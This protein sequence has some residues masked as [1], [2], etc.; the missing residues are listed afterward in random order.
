MSKY[1]KILPAPAPKDTTTDEISS[2]ALV[3]TQNLIPPIK[4]TNTEDV[5][6][7]KIPEKSEGEN[8][9][10]KPLLE[11]DPLKNVAQKEGQIKVCIKKEIV[12]DQDESEKLEKDTEMLS[13]HSSV[14]PGT[15][16]L[17]TPISESVS[18][19]LV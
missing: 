19:E 16:V 12:E 11:S 1:V 3:D 2:T 13:E 8:K 6:P 9:S 7:E 4:P 17:T 10:I 5:E 14:T 18:G 15:S